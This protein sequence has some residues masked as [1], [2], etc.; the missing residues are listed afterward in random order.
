MS[1]HTLFT[2]RTGLFLIC[3]FWIL[4]SATAQNMERTLF[5]N[6]GVQRAWERDFAY[7]PLVYSGAAAAFTLGYA[8]STE[9]KRDEVFL[10]FSRIPMQN[11]FNAELAGTHAQVMTY[12]FYTTGWVA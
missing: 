11:A 2:S 9:R 12:T 10:H 8:Q 3:L 7:S 1:F 5:W 6:A 4:G